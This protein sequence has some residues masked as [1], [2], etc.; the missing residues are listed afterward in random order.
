MDGS[1]VI[2]TKIKIEYRTYWNECETC[3]SYDTTYVTLYKDGK[4]ICDFYKDGHFGGG[5]DVERP[6]VIIPAILEKLGYEVEFD[7]EYGDE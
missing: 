6:S 5:I 7:E 4:E 2:L 3:G 1:L